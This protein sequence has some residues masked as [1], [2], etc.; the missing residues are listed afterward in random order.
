MIMVPEVAKYVIGMLCIVGIVSTLLA[1]RELRRMQ[2]DSPQLLNEVGI[3]RIDWWFR[4]I[5][6]VYMLAFG[7]RRRKVSSKRRLIFSTLCIT[8]PLCA[9]LLVLF[10]QVG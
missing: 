10:P 5:A 1:T 9:L 2:L 6:G 3:E 8:Y 4:C 7:S